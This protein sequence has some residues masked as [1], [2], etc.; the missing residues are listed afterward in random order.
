MS[1]SQVIDI[2]NCHDLPGKI[3]GPMAADTL[4]PLAEQLGVDGILAMYHD[5]GLIPFK[6][7]HFD[8]GVNTTIGLPITRTSP[9][10]GV[11]YG[12]AGS[13]SA[14]PESTRSAIQLAW[15]FGGK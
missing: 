9:D 14:N 3:L 6:T 12:I 15:S 8:S 4:F 13:N 5:Q 7:L 11:A 10:H 1:T 2:E